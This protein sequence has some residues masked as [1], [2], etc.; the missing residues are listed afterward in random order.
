VDCFVPRNDKNESKTDC[1]VLRNDK[2]ESKVD[3]FDSYCMKCGKPLA[4]AEKE[5]CD[6][7]KKANHQ[8]YMGRSLWSHKPPVNKA[9]YDFKYH[10]QRRIGLYFAR[11]LA[12]TYGE[13]V[14]RWGI[15]V[16]MPIPLHKKRQR[17]RGY[18]QAGIIANE[19][20]KLLDIPVN[21]D[22]LKRI[23]YTNPQKKLN[24]TER[25][26]NMAHAFRVK[27]DLR[28]T[29]TVL[30]IDDIYTTGSTISEAA[31]GLISAGVKRV[32]F[33]TVSIGQ[34]R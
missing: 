11:E 29:K 27:S 20:G 7:C 16:I 28:R 4:S 32:Y 23:S 2:N 6:D 9:L 22:E 18:N 21:S 26:K 14:R 33:L 15:D 3:C 25:S 31:R 17:I 13:L 1:L 10:N 12:E 30:L 24:D 34:G 5:F 19:L 8:F